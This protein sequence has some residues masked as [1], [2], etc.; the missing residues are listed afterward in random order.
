VPRALLLSLSPLL[1]EINRES[2]FRCGGGVG[3]HRIRTML[4]GYAN[5]MISPDSAL[6]REKIPRNEEHFTTDIRKRTPQNARASS[7]NY[8]SFYYIIIQMGRGAE[9]AKSVI[10]YVRERESERVRLSATLIDT[11]MAAL[12]FLHQIIYY[13][14][15]IFLCHPPFEI[16]GSKISGPGA[17]ANVFICATLAVIFYSRHCR[18]KNRT[19]PFIVA[20][21]PPSLRT[22]CI[23]YPHLVLAN[24]L[25]SK[26]RIFQ[27]R[28]LRCI[29]LSSFCLSSMCLVLAAQLCHFIKMMFDSV[30]TIM[31]FNTIIGNLEEKYLFFLL[32]DIFANTKN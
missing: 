32:S 21:L 19:R 20:S 23:C 4:H 9:S 14:W 29:S 3:A 24:A 5:V 31:K 7:A 1:A 17:H 6:K 18:M 22:R 26:S 13:L 16:N 30:M 25:G 11:P 15:P 27:S 8:F 10:L 2:C 12:L 28:L